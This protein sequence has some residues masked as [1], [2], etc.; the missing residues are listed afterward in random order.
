MSTSG[1][2]RGLLQGDALD[3]RVGM[4]VRQMP[5]RSFLAID[6]RYA[7]RPVLVGQATNLG[8]L[9]LDHRFG[10]EADLMTRTA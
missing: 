10:S 7:Q 5:F 6:F 3:E 2:R 9:P 8:M 4:T 1:E